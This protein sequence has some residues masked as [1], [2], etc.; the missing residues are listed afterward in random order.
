MKLNVKHENKNNA[1]FLISMAKKPKFWNLFFRVPKNALLALPY[2]R[3]SLEFHY[4]YH[5]DLQNHLSKAICPPWKLT[6]EGFKE[7]C[8]LPLAYI[9]WPNH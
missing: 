5:T 6:K 7:I 8:P 4:M 9:P 3:C 1:R 2:L